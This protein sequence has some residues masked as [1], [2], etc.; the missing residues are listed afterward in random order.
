MS[1][2][3]KLFVTLCVV[4]MLGASAGSSW[5]GVVSLQV[6]IDDL[7]DTPTVSVFSGSTDVTATSGLIILGDSAG[8]FLHFTL[9]ALSPGAGIFYR[10]LFEDVPG[11][12]LSDRLLLTV[13]VS[14]HDVRFASDPAT[15]TPPGGAIQILPGLVED[16]TSQ[17]MLLIPDYQFFVQSDVPTAERG[18]VPGPATLL[19]LGSG[20]AALAGLGWSRHRRA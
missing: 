9:P 18:D 6:R 19:L 2:F 11:G 20:L 13:G 8:E 17:L 10:D 12:I 14:L 16:G 4:V 3:S 1:I 5:A 15:I 7:T